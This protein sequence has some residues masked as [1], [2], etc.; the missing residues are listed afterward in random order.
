MSE[1]KTFGPS[2]L[3]Q[4]DTLFWFVCS[5][6]TVDDRTYGDVIDK[7]PDFLIHGAPLG[8]STIEEIELVFCYI[9]LFHKDFL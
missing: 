1:N 5:G 8:E 3:A 9:Y 2:C 7:F 6:R 4:G